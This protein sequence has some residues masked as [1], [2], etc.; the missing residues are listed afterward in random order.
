[1]YLNFKD[2][3]DRLN[4]NEYRKIIDSMFQYHQGIIPDFSNNRLLEII[5]QQFKFALDENKKRYE[6]IVERNANN[7]KKGGRP[8]SKITEKN[9]KNPVGYLKPK[10]TQRNP[11]K[12]KKADI[13]IDNDIDNDIEFS[14]ENINNPPPPKGGDVDDEKQ[15]RKIIGEDE[16]GYIYEEHEHEQAKDVQE[17]PATIKTRINR[18]FNRRDTTAWSEKEI[19]AFNAIIKR[20]DVE[21]ELS[22]IE[23]LYQSCYLYKRRDVITFLNNWTVELD[24]ATQQSTNDS[25]YARYVPHN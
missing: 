13:D 3:L 14:N 25:G 9:P 20:N 2:T 4:D 8:A 16:F 18:L 1:M 24:R 15:E 6:N 11:K 19:K 17:Q 22:E 7:G 21:T 12:P 5:W 10:E 23:R